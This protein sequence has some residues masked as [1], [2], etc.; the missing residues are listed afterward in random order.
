MPNLNV[1]E[2]WVMYDSLSVRNTLYASEANAGFF[3][4]FVGFGQQQDHLFFKRRSEGNV[5]LAYCNQLSEDRTDFVMQ[6]FQVGLLFIAPPTTM[7]LSGN[8]PA[9]VQEVLPSWWTQ[10]LPRHCS[11]SL[12][13]G[14]DTNLKL[15]AMMMSPGYGPVCDGAAL[16][17]DDPGTPDQFYPEFIWAS[18]QG[19]PTPGSRYW[20]AGGTMQKPQPIGIPKNELVELKVS[21]SEYAR[22]FLTAIGGPGYY[23]FGEVA[24]SYPFPT[25]YS[26]QAAIWGYR[27][28]QQRGELRAS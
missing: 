18:T 23:E 7:D 24:D 2:P 8:S 3:T 11:A 14:Q 6:A 17:V 13:I 25:S 20:I 22:N 27:E 15:Q 10:E 9:E 12:K 5:H 28:V 4:S 19:L 21:I 26:I 1:R 16:G